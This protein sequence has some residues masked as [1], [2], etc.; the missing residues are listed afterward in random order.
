M[1]FVFRAN[2]I[3]FSVNMCLVACGH[4]HAATSCNKMTFLTPLNATCT[5][6]IF[7]WSV[8]ISKQL[9]GAL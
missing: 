2:V 6:S 1:P 7:V 5:N 4:T 9:S 3:L 8:S